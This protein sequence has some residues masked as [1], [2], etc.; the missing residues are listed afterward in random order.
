[1]P[2]G[3]GGFANGKPGCGAGSLLLGAVPGLLI[4]SDTDSSVDGFVHVQSPIW[5]V[6]PVDIPVTDT[7]SSDEMSCG[8]IIEQASMRAA[9]CGAADC[10][11]TVAPAPVAGAFDPHPAATQH[12]AAAAAISA[13]GR[14]PT[15]LAAPF[16]SWT[17][18]RMGLLPVL[19]TTRR[20]DRPSRGEISDSPTNS[21]A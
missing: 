19:P 7:P 4:V 5:G 8:A 15:P 6:L 17:A 16:S 1:M 9:R 20:Y 18:I 14:E 3:P 10:D 13:A 12:S 21:L 2:S 11:G